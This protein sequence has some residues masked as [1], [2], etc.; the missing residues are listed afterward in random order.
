VWDEERLFLLV[1]LCV[2]IKVDQPCVHGGAASWYMA[3][4]PESLRQRTG[5]AF[6]EDIAFYITP[7][8]FNISAM[9]KDLAER[10]HIWQVWEQPPQ[11]PI[12]PLLV[13]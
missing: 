12:E 9:P 7:W 3:N 5:T 8:G 2:L 13:V 10:T 4:I 6:W 11:L 1:L